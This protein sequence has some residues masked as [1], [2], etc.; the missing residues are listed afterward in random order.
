MQYSAGGRVMEQ[1]VEWLWKKPV[2]PSGWAAWHSTQAPVW[3]RA[4]PMGKCSGLIGAPPQSSPFRLWPVSKGA[5]GTVTDQGSVHMTWAQPHSANM[6]P[7]NSS[8]GTGRL[9]RL[10]SLINTGDTL[11][12]VADVVAMHGPVNEV[13]ARKPKDNNH[14]FLFCYF[15]SEPNREITISHSPIFPIFLEVE[16]LPHN[17]L[18]KNQLTAPT[19]RKMGFFFCHPPTLC[20]T[21]PSADACHGH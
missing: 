2:L 12:A 18:C 9:W 10:A 7:S 13:V 14:R 19:D 15:I 11:E 8:I 3:R 17:S 1:V 20:A 4:R 5:L 21:V 16:D 6:L